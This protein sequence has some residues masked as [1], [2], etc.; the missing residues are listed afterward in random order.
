MMEVFITGLQ[1]PL[2]EYK[3]NLS[4][5]IAHIRSA[6]P[7]AEIILIT[8]STYDQAASEALQAAVGLNDFPKDRTDDSAKAYAEA[9]S[10][11][12]EREG[13][14]AVKSYDIH[15]KMIDGGIEG[16]KLLPDG[17]HHSARGYAVRIPQNHSE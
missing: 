15:R 11:V 3:S 17:L 10:E 8:P 13:V 14:P 2:E 6:H 12:A 7:S 1:V 5:I 9:C 16:W 4:A